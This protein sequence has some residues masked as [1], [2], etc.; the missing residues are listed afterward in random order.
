MTLD[1]N[2]VAASTKSACSGADGGGSYVVQEMTQDESRSL[3]TIRFSL[4]E[5]TTQQEID[6][7]IEILVAHVTKMRKFQSS[8]DQKVA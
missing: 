4:G 5:D 3:S 7:A 6:R 2:G 8:M 1:S